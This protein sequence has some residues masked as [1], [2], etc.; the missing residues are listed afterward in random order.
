M[1]DVETAAGRFL[2][3][4]V[5]LDITQPL[6]RGVPV[7][8]GE[9][10]DKTL[11]CP[12]EYEFLPDFLLHLWSYWAC[13]QG[14]WCSVQLE[15]GAVQQYSKKLRCIPKKGRGGAFGGD[16]FSGERGGPAWRL[17]GGGFPN[18]FGGSGRSSLSR[19]GSDAPSWRRSAGE[20]KDKEV[21]GKEMEDEM[22][23]RDDLNA[24]PVYVSNSTL[25]DH[26][27]PQEGDGGGGVAATGRR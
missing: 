22:A 14:V 24:K 2:R 17:G 18:S 12:V 11:R 7:L 1:D 20:K 13:R 19:D 23:K 4:K 25:H 6:M 15:K 10:Q 21:H 3:I 16:R 5:K 26:V 8:V 9:G 27:P